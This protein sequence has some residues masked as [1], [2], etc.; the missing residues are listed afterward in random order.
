MRGISQSEEAGAACSRP[1][2]QRSAGGGTAVCPR[3]PP[4][5]GVPAAG[6]PGPQSNLGSGVTWLFSGKEFASSSRKR[7]AFWGGG[8]SVP[9]VSASF[10]HLDFPQPKS[11]G[12]FWTG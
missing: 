11:Q 7:T 12:T 10:R 2:T 9:F 1:Q 5:P 4:H 6:Q 3:L 8:V